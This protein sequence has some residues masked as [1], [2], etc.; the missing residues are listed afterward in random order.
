MM[1][2]HHTWWVDGPYGVE[3]PYFFSI[4]IMNI[5]EVMGSN[6]KIF[7]FAIQN[8]IELGMV[9]LVNSI[10]DSCLC[11]LNFISFRFMRGGA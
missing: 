3:E 10:T 7:K 1:Y 5:N 4:H 6:V 8:F 11:V 2:Y 9:L